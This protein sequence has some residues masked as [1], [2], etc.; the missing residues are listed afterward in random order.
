VAAA[1]ATSATGSGGG[2]PGGAISPPDTGSGQG[3]AG[4]SMTWNAV[5]IMSG[6]ALL[7]AGVL[8]LKRFVR[9]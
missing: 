2:A 6:A 5:W 1:A 4:E 7:L 9:R 8:A 3:S